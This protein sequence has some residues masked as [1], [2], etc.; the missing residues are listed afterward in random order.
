M[1]PGPMV[2]PV[3]NNVLSIS[4]DEKFVSSIAKLHSKHG[5]ILSLS[6][7]GHGL[8][9]IWVQGYDLVKEVLHDPRFANRSIFGP[10]T[11][12][13][14]EKGL[15][16]ATAEISKVRRKTMLQCMRAMGVGKTAFSAGVEEEIMSLLKYLDSFAGKPLYIQVRLS[17]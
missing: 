9:D 16:W 15:G 4:F 6:L 17:G 8:W 7:V 1:P 5:S 2:F 10:M 14:L 12:L 3:V 13:N 11:E